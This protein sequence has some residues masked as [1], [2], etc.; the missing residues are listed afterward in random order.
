M[1]KLENRQLTGIV[2]VGTKFHA[3][4]TAKALDDKEMLSY[5]IAGKK[6]KNN[7]LSNKKV[8]NIQ[9]PQYIGAAIRKSKILSRL[10]HYNLISDVL[11]DNIS[12]GKINTNINFFIGFNNYVLNQ[13]KILKPKNIVLILDQRTAHGEVEKR[14]GLDEWGKVPVNL[15]PEMMKRKAEE[16]EIADY[17]L[18]PSDFVYNSMVDNDVDE[19]KLILLPYGYNPDLFFVKDVNKENNKFNLIF[20]GSICHRKGCEYLL[21]AF[22]NICR[23]YKDISLTMVGNVEKEFE[24]T[25][26]KYKEKINYLGFVDNEKLVELYNKADVFVFPSLCEG[27]A[28]VTY[29]AAACGLPLIVTENTGSIV[30]NKKEGLVI[31]ERSVVDIERAIIYMY[32]NPAE[33]SKMRSQVLS[34]IQNYTW[35]KYGERLSEIIKSVCK[36]NTG[37]EGNTDACINNSIMVPK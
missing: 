30:Q 27:S 11:F 15:H 16:I 32:E 6:I 4:Y 33:L 2:S 21:K 18:V 36:I 28:L 14:I 13:M 10:F 17:I 9:L 24:E 3:Y 34:T 31:N 37:E 22:D 7:I 23:Q 1:D 20:V 25:F 26:D 29:E 5:L 8:L 35:E 19:R 12:K